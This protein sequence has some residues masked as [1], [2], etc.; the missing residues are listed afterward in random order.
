MLV[1][2]FDPVYDASSRI[3]ILGSFP[4]VR[5]REEGFYYGHP[6][7]RFWRVLA[8]VLGEDAPGSVPEKKAMLLRHGIALWDAAA[9]CEI[10]GSLDSAMK[11]AEANDITPILRAARIETVITNGKKAHEIYEK[12]IFPRCGVKDVVLPSTSAANA[13]FSTEELIRIWRAAI[14]PESETEGKETC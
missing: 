4:S 12:A 7:N 3:L 9:Q 11:R 14:A 1:H 6:R 8:A 10:A 5:S 2:P 13:S